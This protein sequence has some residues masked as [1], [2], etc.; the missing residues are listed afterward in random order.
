MVE[1]GKVD[2]LKYVGSVANQNNEIE[3]VKKLHGL[4]S[5]A[6][7]TKRQPLVGEVSANFC[8]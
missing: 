6:K 2:S 7:Y 5:K 8:G 4:S 3:E 1:F